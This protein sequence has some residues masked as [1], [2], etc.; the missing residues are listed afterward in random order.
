MSRY[1]VVSE[2]FSSG[3]SYV[4]SIL[5]RGYTPI[6]VNTLKAI[7]E[8]DTQHIKAR[9][10]LIAPYKDRVII[11]NETEDFNELVEELKKYDIEHVVIGCENGVRTGERIARALGLSGNDPDTTWRRCTKAGMHQSLK[12]ANLRYIRTCTVKNAEEAE[13]FWRE[14][15]LKAA[16]MKFDEG[17]GS[18]GLKICFSLEDVLS[19]F[20]EV[21][22]LWD[23]M[24]VDSQNILIQEYIGGTEYIVNTISYDGRHMVTDVWRYNKILSDTGTLLYDK[25]V[26]EKDPSPGMYDMVE[27]AYSVLDAVGMRYGPCHMEMKY[28]GDGPVLIETNCRPMGGGMNN[29]YLEEILGFTITDLT[30]DIFISPGRFEEFK[31]KLMRPRCNAIIKFIILNRDVT[32]S[33]GPIVEMMKHLDSFRSFSMGYTVGINRYSKTID[34]HSSPL[35]IYLCNSDE[36]RLAKDD[37]IIDIA[38]EHYMDLMFS[39]RERMQP[40]RLKTDMGVLTSRI[41]TNKRYLIVE[42]DERR[43]YLN[44][45]VTSAT[46]NDDAFDGIIISMSESALVTDRLHKLIR[47]CSLLRGGGKLIVTPETYGNLSGG[48][49]SIELLMHL[50]KIVPDLPVPES[51]GIVSGTKH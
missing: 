19:Y 46:D 35:T 38:E 2:A 30:L 41:P 50:M 15:G 6:V 24:L 18:A 47:C 26:R 1:I 28:D 33:M 12:E 5:E 49:G 16:V 25:A 17:R 34:L 21:R 10:E 27:Y 40:V 32:A 42:N 11:L 23:D 3:F 44:G 43:I 31:K 4:N 45:M 20:D 14:N 7:E 29:E 9:D 13:A 51:A 39:R 22:G 8:N 36:L 48:A 37:R